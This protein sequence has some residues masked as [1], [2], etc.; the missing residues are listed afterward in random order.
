MAPAGGQ[1][2]A[3]WMMR[4]FSTRV[5]RNLTGCSGTVRLVFAINPLNCPSN[6]VGFKK[7][8]LRTLEE[9]S[10]SDTNETLLLPIKG[11]FVR[12]RAMFAI[13]H[14]RVVDRDEQPGI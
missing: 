13:N 5:F 12:V 14:G 3:I 4:V 9:L 8:E 7:I 11:P 1:L 6:E 10:Q 2:L